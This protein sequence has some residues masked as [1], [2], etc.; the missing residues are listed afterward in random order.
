MVQ[1]INDA[2]EDTYSVH[3]KS[4]WDV[5]IFIICLYHVYSLYDM[6]VLL[7]RITKYACII[8]NIIISIIFFRGRLGLDGM[9][10]TVS[11]HD[12]QKSNHI[13]ITYKNNTFTSICRPSG[14]NYI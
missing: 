14:V 9:K 3:L 10:M 1:I 12:V 7:S 11:K 8:C 2:L 5:K 6:Y 4:F 13:R